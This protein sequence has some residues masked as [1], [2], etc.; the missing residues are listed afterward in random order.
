MTADGNI[1]LNVSGDGTNDHGDGLNITGDNHG[2]ISFTA[3]QNITINAS[4][5]RGDAIIITDD[6]SSGD[7]TFTATNGNIEI[8][9]GN[10]GI[11]NNGSQGI[12]LESGQANIITG[13]FAQEKTNGG[14]QGDGIR[15]QN[16]GS[17]EVTA[18]TYNQIKGFDE[19]LYIHNSVDSGDGIIVT[20]NGADDNGFGNIIVGQDNGIQSDGSASLSVTALNGKNK[21]YGENSAILNNGSGSIIITAG[22]RPDE[23]DISLLA[24][25]EGADNLIG[26]ED[27]DYSVN[28][29]ESDGTGLTDIY[30]SHDN[31]IFGTDNGILSSDAGIINVEAG[32][33]NTIGLYTDDNDVQHISQTGI[34]VES[35]SVSLTAGNSNIINATNTGVFS[36]D[37]INITAKYDNIIKGEQSEGIKTKSGGSAVIKSTEGSNEI[38][39]GKQGVYLDGSSAKTT[40]NIVAKEDNIISGGKDNV[41][42]GINSNNS[43]LT[44]TSEYGNNKISGGDSAVLGTLSS[45]INLNAYNAN[46]INSNIQYGVDALYSSNIIM[47]AG[48]NELIA[49]RAIS[50]EGN[51][52]IEIY[53]NNESTDI[54]ERDNYIQAKYY[55]GSAYGI[56]ARSS[57]KVVLSAL[58]GD[59]V[60]TSDN[61]G[62]YAQDE[63]TKVKLEAQ[64]NSVSSEHYGIYLQKNSSIDLNA[65]NSNTLT[66]NDSTA[67][68]AQNYGNRYAIYSLSESSIT[69]EAS[70][71][72]TL[73]GAV[74]AKGSNT[75]VELSAG[76]Q[77]YVASFTQSNTL[78]DLNTD[79]AFSDAKVI[80]ALYAEEGAQISLSGTT[81]ILRTY[82]DSSDE[83][84]RERVVW[85]YNGE[86]G[87]GTSITID[88]YTEIAT[89][90]YNDSPENLDVAVAAGTAVNLTEEQVTNNLSMDEDKRAQVQINYV[91]YE[92]A[93]STI[94]GDILAAYA[95]VVNINPQDPTT[96][97]D[98]PYGINIKGD[99][100][101]GNGGV[102]NI[103]IGSG[104][105]QGR[106][107]DYAEAGSNI[108]DVQGWHPETEGQSFRNPA[109]SSTI[110]KGGAVNLTMGKDSVWEVTKQSW[111]TKITTA[112]NYLTE[113]EELNYLIQEPYGQGWKIAGVP[114]IDLTS[115]E[116]N[117][118]QGAA[119]TV[120]EFNGDAQFRMNLDGNRE[121]SDMLY[122]KEANGDYVILLDNP[123]TDEDILQDGKYENLRFATVGA[124]SNASFRVFN[125]DSGIYN[126]EYDVETRDYT[127]A[128]EQDD[129]E[130][131]NDAEASEGKPGQTN[132]DSLLNNDAAEVPSAPQDSTTTLVAKNTVNEETNAADNQGPTNYVLVVGDNTGD[133][134]LSDAG[135]TV[136]SMSRANY[137]N[138]VYM[139]TLNKRQGQ[140]HF[141][142][143][144]QDDGM[145]VR[146]RFDN[147]GQE[148]E[149]RSHN[150]MVEIGYD[151][152]ATYDS[153]DW[154]FGA[155]LDYMHGQ[156]DYNS[157]NGDGELDRLGAWLYGTWL[158]D[159]GQYLDLILKYGHIENDFEVVTP[160][161]GN[162]TGSYGND[163]YS[164][165]AEYGYKFADEDSGIF[166]EPQVQLQYAHVTG[167]DYTTS[168][169][170]K[171]DVEAIDSLI[172]RAG[173]RFGADL[174]Q[175]TT[176]VA[177]YLRADVMHEF[178]GD[179]DISASDDTG[180]MSVSYDNDDTWYDVG[181]G[182]SV[183]AHESTY[184]FMEAEKLF[185]ANYSDTY[186]FS[187]G[188]RHS[189]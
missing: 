11:D 78:G 154:H 14:N 38:Y 135:K 106:I 120:Y 167:A 13:G 34:N 8:T 176:P 25:Y 144:N 29:I 63:N 147:L 132:V 145:W 126:K 175:D 103:D 153:G 160:T 95:G 73:L 52:T 24:N 81:N 15:I 116:N 130:I 188:A 51:S 111:V 26:V 168:Q 16:S 90:R 46:I 71:K 27:E 179:Q 97:D 101:A 98:G 123:I 180:Y 114:L 83:N 129:N 2:T 49:E 138:A 48:R 184:F 107:D 37:S 64:E 57:S 28:G 76:T 181:L 124:E 65:T 115:I 171:V 117:A 100:L 68:S 131:Y 6:K 125:R 157:V 127:A 82:A 88:G 162:V 53:A 3:G 77:N 56:N 43:E 44:V 67:V 91:N 36:Q 110:Y 23:S 143:P 136:L 156:T 104:T 19:G 86:S 40:V 85:A 1:T 108:E 105:L 45:N 189:F 152:K 22:Q 109:F 5:K 134:E 140:A 185:G 92:G 79:P 158:G 80:S 102:M 139:D 148:G 39:G 119:L 183:K 70:N 186:I 66:A 55:D 33:N 30:A 142:D 32:N 10:N 17:V 89:D 122:I 165:S 94:N 174:A 149:F 155:A 187:I 146:M 62:I 9:G 112:D 169:Y 137:F 59:N 177:L 99:L 60:I 118:N 96:R 163:V 20:A 69:L 133:Q 75:S 47:N 93:K 12:T 50:A 150:T 178:M 128:D 113:D 61:Y 87:S 74:Y 4:E 173:F 172:G 166:F 42:S 18:G 182:F 54:A 159:D 84:Q 21:I 7:V 164:L 72:N 141:A 170:T 121:N 161:N 35:G 58:Y 41:G 151:R 31:I